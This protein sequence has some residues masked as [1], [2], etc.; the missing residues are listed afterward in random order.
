MSRICPTN[1]AFA[2][3]PAED[4]ANLVSPQN[5]T[6]LSNVLQY[7]ILEGRYSISQ[8]KALPDGTILKTLNGDS[9]VIT[10]KDGLKVNGSPIAEDDIPF[11]GGW[12][13]PIGGAL[14]PPSAVDNK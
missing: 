2:A 13:H 5:R 4:V 9:V 3:L 10:N 6:K 7:H 8:L 12:I 1:S 11:S 14:T